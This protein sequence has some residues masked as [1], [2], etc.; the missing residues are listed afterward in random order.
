MVELIFEHG[1]RTTEAL[2]HVV[3]RELEMNATGPGS[4]G[5]VSREEALDLGHD[6]VEMPRLRARWRAEQVR[7][8]RVADPHDRHVRLT[9]CSQE[10]RQS[11]VHTLGAHASDQGQPP[12][13]AVRVQPFCQPEDI[14]G[15]RIRPELDSDRIVDPGEELDVGAAELARALADPE[16]VRGAVVRAAR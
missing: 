9:H 15:R 3:A 4:G 6:R 1:L 8:H 7:V 16:H 14:V 5:T 2:G 10:R 11:L 12:G 13:N